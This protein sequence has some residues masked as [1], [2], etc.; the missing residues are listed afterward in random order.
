MGERNCAIE[1][2][3]AL[4]FRTS[5]YCLRHKDDHPWLTPPEVS[6]DPVQKSVAPKLLGEYGRMED[7]FWGSP[8][9]WII[10]LTAWLFPP[11]LLLVIMYY[12]FNRPTSKEDAA[13]SNG[14]PN[15]DSPRDEGATGENSSETQLPWW[16]IDEETQ[17]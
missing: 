12:L 3:N 10:A 1:A 17:G 4:E 11:I 8:F 7:E 13:P 6:P 5:G 14:N 16:V 2:C 9:G 15:A